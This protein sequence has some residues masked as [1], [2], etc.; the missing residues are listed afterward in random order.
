MTP[1][2][3]NSVCNFGALALSKYVRALKQD[4]AGARKANDIEHV[5]NLRVASRRLRATLPLFSDCFR[6]SQVKNWMK[7][8][9]SVTR[10]LGAA[11]D[12]DV[13]I[14]SLTEVFKSV[15][16]PEQRPGLRRLMLRSEQER[17]ALQDQ[18]VTAIDR[19]ERSRILPKM[20]KIIG[21]NPDPAQ[22]AIPYSHHLYKLAYRSI[23]KSLDAV[24]AF[25]PYVEQP[26]RVDELHEMRVAAKRLRYT[27]ETFWP[28]YP[29][30]FT[31][32]INHARIMQE[33][34]GDIHD[35][36]VWGELLPQFVQ[37]ERR[38]TL[39]YYGSTRPMRRLMPGFRF[40]LRNRRARR[41]KQYQA[42]V[43]LWRCWQDEGSW[44]A[45]EE[46]ISRP[47]AIAKDLYPPAASPDP[48]NPER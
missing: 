26:E 34:L 48:E 28:L 21:R 17:L 44:S 38:R 8:I 15:T 1:K 46:L 3:N 13:Q 2:D 6:A 37:Q 39:E 32:H 35:C 5:H 18:V 24:L 12:K 30:S 14:D 42:F 25:S 33:T 29:E 27:L 43:D 4:I 9:R 10:A 11:R 7:E 41:E 20:R 19:L 40:F 16:K 31:A 36:D 23:A 47:L 45:L 22:S